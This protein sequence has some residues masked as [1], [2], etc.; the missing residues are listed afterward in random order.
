MF[1]TSADC[2][3][4]KQGLNKLPNSRIP[5]RHT[6]LP[7]TALLAFAVANGFRNI[8]NVVQRLKAPHIQRAVG[9]STGLSSAKRSS[10]FPF[11]YVEVM[12][13]PGGKSFHL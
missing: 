9:D 1:P 5:F 11:D 2:D 10:F 4:A 12:A 13:C 7:Q 3:T 6:K 8:Q